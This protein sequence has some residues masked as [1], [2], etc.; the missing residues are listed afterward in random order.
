VG[1]GLVCCSGIPAAAAAAAACAADTPP[2]RQAGG[3]TYAAEPATMEAVAEA[4]ERSVFLGAC[5]FVSVHVRPNK[6]AHAFV[7][8]GGR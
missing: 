3:S 6:Y 7:R 1:V 2:V 8:V 5:V 4:S